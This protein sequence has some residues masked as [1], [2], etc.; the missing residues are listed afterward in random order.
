MLDELTQA[1]AD[2]AGR[3]VMAPPG[4]V[5][6][7]PGLQGRDDAPSDEAGVPSVPH[8]IGRVGSYDRA[9]AARPKRRLGDDLV[10]EAAY[11]QRRQWHVLC[12][13]PAGLGPLRRDLVEPEVKVMKRIRN[14][15]VCIEGP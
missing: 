2:Q 7:S 3:E 8:A 10:I 14:V 9:V 12:A 6:P 15:E 4:G 5:A 1:L 13:R 11:R